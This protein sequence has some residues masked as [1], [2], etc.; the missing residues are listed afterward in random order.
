MRKIHNPSRGVIDNTNAEK[1]TYRSNV[2]NRVSFHPVSAGNKD[3]TPDRKI[4]RFSF[5]LS[6]TVSQILYLFNAALEKR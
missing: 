1:L 4:R 2:F 5:W 6:C 3:K